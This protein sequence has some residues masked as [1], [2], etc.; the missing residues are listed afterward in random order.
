MWILSG[1]FDEFSWVMGVTWNHFVSCPQLRAISAS[2]TVYKAINHAINCNPMK[3]HTSKTVCPL[4]T[5]KHSTIVEADLP[6]RSSAFLPTQRVVFT[7]GCKK[8]GHVTLPIFDIFIIYHFPPILSLLCVRYWV[9]MWSCSSGVYSFLA[10]HNTHEYV[11]GINHSTL[12]NKHFIPFFFS[13][14]FDSLM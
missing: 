9:R 13:K 7:Q 8:S 11:I 10:L 12:L 3:V 6:W 14:A 2:S 4:P 5:P 1:K